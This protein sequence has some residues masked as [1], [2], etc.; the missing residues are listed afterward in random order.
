MSEFIVGII[1]RIFFALLLLPILLV[2]ATPIIVVGAAFRKGAYSANVR[3]GF[4][5]V[6]VIW[7][8]LFSQIQ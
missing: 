6:L 7:G 8:E 2:V 1:S 3:A 5:H 4:R